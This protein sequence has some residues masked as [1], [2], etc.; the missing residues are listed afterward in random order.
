M[1]WIP[2]GI[3]VL[4]ITPSHLG[5]LLAGTDSPA[6]LPRRLLVVGGE[7]LS[8]QLV[9]DVSLRAPA[10]RIVNHYGPTE[11]TVG[12]CTLEVGSDS[13][14]HRPRTVPI[15]RP[16][17]NARAY[18]V[19]ASGEVVPAGVPGELLLGGAGVAGGY[20]GRAEETAA[21]FVPDAYGDGSVYRT[22]DRARAL[23]D[24]T[25]EFLGRVD[26]QLKIRGYR[27]EPGEIEAALARHPAVKQAAV[28][29]VAD[30]AGNARLVAYHVTGSRVTGDELHS[31][32]AESLPDYMIPAT[33][34]SLD[35]LPLT[36]SGKIDRL[37]LPDPETTADRSA[38][39][40][41][42]RNDVEAEIARI[43]GELLGVERVGVFDDFFELGGH[44]LLAT[45]V[46]MRVRRVYGD[47][48]LQAM[49]MAP[50]PAGLAEVI[51]AS[52]AP[53]EAAS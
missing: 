13:D 43:W 50:T 3:D 9:D 53:A 49:F 7:A 4:K 16:L 12:I 37:A 35:A 8:W 19:D 1:R 51:Q 11:T 30:A 38:D 33:F 15:G 6:V 22:G 46:I 34:V 14:R 10:L 52:A 32:L 41:A 36:A 24:G 25:I 42:P 31:F 29:A 26:D 17:A 5:A 18:V 21:R 39:Y 48:P 44:S 20:V 40:V 2:R 27:V 47:V 45:Q 28:R 23:P